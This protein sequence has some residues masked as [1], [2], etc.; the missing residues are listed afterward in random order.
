MSTN[1]EEKSTDDTFRQAM[2]DVEPRVP[3][4]LKTSTKAPLSKQPT[5]AQLQRRLNAV[6]AGKNA[7]DPNYLTLGEVH[8]LDPLETLCWK[9]DG[10]QLGVFQKLR[11]GGYEIEAELDLHGLTVKEARSV[12]YGFLEHAS[13]KGWRTVLVAHGK[14]QL[15]ATPARLKSY[16]AHWLTQAPEVIAFHSAVAQQG[17]VGAVY[18]LIR[19]RRRCS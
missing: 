11:N 15:S 1:K 4:R 6:D 2:A 19:K 9:K 7:I 12:L 10:V 17:G 3:S 13:G 5:S 16:V 14:G 18:C 8:Q